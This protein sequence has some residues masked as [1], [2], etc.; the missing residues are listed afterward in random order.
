MAKKSK[1]DLLNEKIVSCERCPRLIK[2][3]RKMATVKRA[4]FRDQTYFG[5]PVPNF[6]DPAARLL[7]IGLAPAAHGANRT[8]RMFTG[9]RSGDFLYRA[10]FQTGFANQ[11]TSRHVG[12]NLRLTDALITATAHCAPPANRPT[13][14]EIANCATFLDQTFTLLSNVRVVL[15]LGKIGF[16]AV[17]AYYF[18]RGWITRKSAY[19]FGHGVLHEFNAV[20]TNDGI[21]K[22]PV[23]LCSYHPSQQNTFTGRLTPAML[24]AV[25]ET[26]RSII[27][28]NEVTQA[29][30]AANQSDP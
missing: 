13:P 8:G 29:D 6:G 15:C 23:I 17:L 9:D 3:C 26:A 25:F 7:I 4:A 19:R 5:K 18:R 16:D 22:P 30:T 12:D 20:R 11:P 1:F 21:I 10:M 27:D 24:K 2:H 14:R 28:R